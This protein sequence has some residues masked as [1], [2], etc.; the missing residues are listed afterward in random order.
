MYWG[1]P[2]GKIAG[3]DVY[4]VSTNTEE[5]P[6]PIFAD[7]IFWRRYVAHPHTIRTR[8]NLSNICIL[9]YQELQT[10]HASSSS[11]LNTSQVNYYF[12]LDDTGIP[13]RTPSFIIKK[14]HNPRV[15]TQHITHH[16]TSILFPKVESAFET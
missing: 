11:C 1:W 9:Y 7:G 10:P 12:I 16:I 4:S 8:I 5:H 2:Q 6:A 13:P 14:A 3:G 15:R